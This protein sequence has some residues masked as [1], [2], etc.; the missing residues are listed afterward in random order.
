MIGLSVCN[1]FMVSS[2]ITFIAYSI[3]LFLQIKYINLK[4]N[5]KEEDVFWQPYLQCL[6]YIMIPLLWDRYIHIRKN[7][8]LFLVNKKTDKERAHF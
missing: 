2:V 4:I 6:M 8:E 3:T 5:E 1:E 7:I